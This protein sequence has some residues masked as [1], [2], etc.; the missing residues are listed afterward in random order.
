M[1]SMHRIIF[2]LCLSVILPGCEL[3]FTPYTISKKDQ[4]AEE[5]EEFV[6]IMIGK[7]QDQVT[8]ILGNP[9][10]IYT[11]GTQKYLIYSNQSSADVFWAFFLFIPMG[12]SANEPLVETLNCIKIDIGSSDKV[13]SYEFDS[14]VQGECLYC[15][16]NCLEAFWNSTERNSLTKLDTGQSNNNRFA[17]DLH[18]RTAWQQGD[19]KWQGD[20]VARKY[21]PNADLGHT[22][23]Q[24]YIADIYYEGALGY[25]AD[26]VRA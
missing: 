4:L 25:A 5:R 2:L 9:D 1:G 23:A 11:D 3:I 21:C 18:R 17:S 15:N 12:Y 10:S 16:D 6:G 14:S 13:M 20:R 22:D 19:A 24:H 8:E 26:P 7:S